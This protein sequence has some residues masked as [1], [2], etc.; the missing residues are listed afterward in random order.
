[1]NSEKDAKTFEDLIKGTE[2][3]NT[4]LNSRIKKKADL[5]TD[6]AQVES[7]MVALKSENKYLFDNMQLLKERIEKLQNTKDA[8]CPLCGQSLGAEDRE[9]LLASLKEEGKKGRRF[10]PQKSRNDK[11]L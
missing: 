9:S 2:A 5:E 10:I 11:G 3:K 8:E 1:M 6:L 4:E 7:K